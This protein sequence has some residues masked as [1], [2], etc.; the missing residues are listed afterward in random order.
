MAAVFSFIPGVKICVDRQTK[1]HRVY[2]LT[3]IWPGY[4]ILCTVMHW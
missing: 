1:M 4:Q 3:A 2:G